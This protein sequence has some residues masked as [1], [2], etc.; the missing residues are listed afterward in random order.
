MALFTIANY[1]S[2]FTLEEQA[3]RARGLPGDQTGDAEWQDA[4]AMLAPYPLLLDAMKEL[5][6]PQSDR[7][8]EAGLQ[9]ILDGLRYR[10]E[11]TRKLTLGPMPTP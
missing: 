11:T 4:V 10:L 3:D 5:G 8:F 6:D 7:T 2:G 1:V 9:L